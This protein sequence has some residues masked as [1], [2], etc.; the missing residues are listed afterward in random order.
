MPQTH[1]ISSSVSIPIELYLFL[2]CSSSF[3][4]ARNLFDSFEIVIPKLLSKYLDAMRNPCPQALSLKACP[5]AF[6]KV[7]PLLY[8]LEFAGKCKGF[9]KG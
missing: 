4:V 3:I 7:T 8:L 1:L 9:D 5:A 6:C 2:F